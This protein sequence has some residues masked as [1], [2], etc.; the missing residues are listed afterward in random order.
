M[1]LRVLQTKEFQRVGGTKTIESNFR[2]ITATNIN[3]LKMAK[4]GR[5]R[6]DLY[7]RLNVFPITVPPLRE[8]ENDIP[9]LAYY[10]L[11]EYTKKSKRSL[12][13]IAKTEMDKLLEYHWPGNV[14]ELRNVIERAVILSPKSYLILPDLVG[15]NKEHINERTAVVLDEVVRDHILW[16]LEQ[17][18][19]RIN[20]KNSTSQLLKIN[21]STLRFKMKKLGI[22]IDRGSKLRKEAIP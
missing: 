16:A 18:G 3:L 10:L 21:P 1:L 15:D 17:T 9:L 4:K 13:K 6:E 5:F 8:R 14:R 20:G 12:K 19:N 2:L 7:Y 22:F 11:K